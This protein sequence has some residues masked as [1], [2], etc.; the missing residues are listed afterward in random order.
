MSKFSNLI[1]KMKD[2]LFGGEQAQPDGDK[3]PSKP[4]EPLPATPRTREREQPYFIQIGFDF[5]TSFSKCV[6]RDV[7]TDKAWVH[8]SPVFSNQELP[9]LIPSVFLFR[10][11]SFYDVEDQDT[12]YPE[13]GLYHLKTALVKVALGEVNDPVRNPTDGSCKIPTPVNYVDSSSHARSI[14]WLGCSVQFGIR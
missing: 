11:G 2:K 5:G 1:R 7:M 13:D 6:C 3:Q 10:S 8:I 9:F 12:H 4:P 14:S